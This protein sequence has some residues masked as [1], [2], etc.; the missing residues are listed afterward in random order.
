MF[1]SSRFTRTTQ[2]RQHKH[3]KMNRSILLCLCLCLRL[4]VV[5]V[6]RYDASISTSTSTR[7][8]CLRRTGLHVGFLCLCLCL[9]LS[10]RRTCKAGLSSTAVHSGR[11]HLKTEKKIASFAPE[12]C[13]PTNNLCYGR[14]RSVK[15]IQFSF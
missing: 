5:S 2:R 11:L 4:F 6:N 7:R 9:R 14:I 15:K 12:T 10:L 8:L 1:A 13:F 3:K